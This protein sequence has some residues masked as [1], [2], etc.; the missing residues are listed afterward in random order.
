MKI[1]VVCMDSYRLRDTQM[2]DTS[3]FSDDEILQIAPFSPEMENYWRDA[4][5]TPY[6][7]VFSGKNSEDAC[8][9]AGKEH[10]YDPRALFGIEINIGGNAK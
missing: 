10:G 8:K 4:E 5:V 3:G 1:Y 2:F 7:G 6:I 9:K